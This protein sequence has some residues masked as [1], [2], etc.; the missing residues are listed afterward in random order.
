MNKVYKI[1]WN[2]H[3]FCWKVTSELAKSHSSNNRTSTATGDVAKTGNSKNK[4]RTLLFSLAML[5][6][7][8]WAAIQD[9]TLP[10]G[11]NITSG[12]AQI[13]QQQNN[14]NITQSSQNL[15]TNWE[16]F[17][18]GENAS[19][20]FY[21]PN[22][23]AIAVNRV[24]DNNA[25]QIM[26][27]LNA[28]GQIFL[29]NPNGVIF[30]KTAQV[31]VGGIVAST[32]EM[33]EVDISQGKF[34]LSN[35]STAGHVENHG[36]IIANGGVVAL[37]APTV[38]NTGTIQAPNGVVHLTAADQ[39]TLQL[40]DGSL[41]EYQ[42][43]VGT[44]Q[45]LIDNGGAIQADN[46]AVYLTAK[47]KNSLSQV[48]VN[49]SGIIEANRLSQNAKGEIILLGDM[50]QGTTN[51]S[52]VLKAEGKNGEDGGFIETS[53]ANVK[54]SDSAKVSTQSDTGQT[55]TWLIDP[56]DFTIA[57]TSGDISGATLSSNLGTTN[58][59]IQSDNG[60]TGTDGNIYVNDS[61]IWNTTNALTLNAKNDIHIN[62]DITATNGGKLNLKYGQAT[63]DGGTS[64]Y[65]LNNGAKVNLTVG[66]NFSTQKGSA[67]S[68]IDYTVI[69]DLGDAYSSTGTD[70]QGIRG[71]LFG[72]YV[73]GADIDATATSTWDAG[74]GFIP[75]GNLNYD[76]FEFRGKFDGLGHTITNLSINRPTIN[77]VGLFGRTANTTLHN[78]GLIGAN[79]TGAN[80]VGGLV[81][82]NSYSSINNAYVTGS[83]TGQYYVGG[84]VGYNIYNSSINN[85]Y[86]TGEVSGTYN[87]GGLVG[88]N[89]NYSSID[90][91][92]ATGAVT[93]QY[94]VGGL[95][96][97]NEYTSSV[98]N[99]YATGT[100]TGQLY[101]GGLVGVN[102]IFSSINNAYA[103]G[104]VN[105][106]YD[107][108]GLVGSN[109]YGSISNAY[110]T[111]AVNGG[112]YIGG[113]V[114]ELYSGNISNTYATGAVSGIQ[115]GG[116]VGL[117]VYEGQVNTSYWNVDTS[118]QTSSEGGI[119][120]NSQQFTQG[121]S[122][123]FIDDNSKLG[124]TD[125]VWRIYEGN[126]APLLRSFL[127]ELDL[128]SLNKTTTYTG[129][130][131]TL[132]L[133]SLKTDTLFAASG[134][135]SGKD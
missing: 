92:Y 129:Q 131:Q 55:G 132:D 43:D 121:G 126:T 115:T 40:Q 78:I 1:V 9:T 7:S 44:L 39:V 107:V 99:A 16:T 79:I 68:V 63:A 50:Q 67:G 64:D 23:S 96:G 117:N 14:L 54:I 112:Y 106:Q 111:G 87:V 4:I 20:N 123:A 94:Y 59:T 60:V 95:V 21:Q 8:V 65:Y 33:S 53:A 90:N 31:N 11:A 61:V 10:T 57:A 105:G 35:S 108:G 48:V 125:T 19:V 104:E 84:L 89:K 75:L 37:I 3:L 15:S 109:Y 28:N 18:I 58:F 86:F 42:I 45:G 98:N 36:S 5:P 52:G 120:L 34:T 122:F 25:S 41:T 22:Q 103:T 83:V 134:D 97:F 49:H 127:T 47:A 73:L 82:Y 6:V 2:H 93:G 38:I 69:T 124:G 51:V 80:N 71:N 91:A 56:N 76:A 46:G 13:V 77:D 135:I 26:G 116:L 119:G 133:S 81:G 114:G 62:Q 130:I 30:S 29:L 32:L 72:N 85:A 101:V 27:K 24:L 12:S 118:G 17:N 102:Y 88:R 66:Q 100:V 74:A 70:L 128:S 110:A 113:L